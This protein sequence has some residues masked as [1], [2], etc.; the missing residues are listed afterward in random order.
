MK[1][2]DNI[3]S[4]LGV[5]IGESLDNKSKLKV[6]ASYFSI[7]AYSALKKELESNQSKA[8]AISSLNRGNEISN[9]RLSNFL[10]SVEIEG[11]KIVRSSFNITLFDENEM[12]ALAMCIF[13]RLYL[14]N[15]YSI[16]NE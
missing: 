12:R 4:T 2:I 8:K 14:Y 9:N 13:V 16:K 15:S 10:S 11:A 6:A 7:Y 3:N 1:L 5:D